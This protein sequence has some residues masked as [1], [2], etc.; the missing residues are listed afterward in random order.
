MLPF[1]PVVAALATGNTAMIKP[2]KMV[3]ALGP[4]G[5][6]VPKYLDHRGAMV[7][8]GAG[9]I[10]LLDQDWDLIFHRQPPVGRS[11]TGRPR[12]T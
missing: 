8:G 7:E 6:L 5:E 4:S 3:V 9:A 2:S 12:S 1:G 11:C 10:A